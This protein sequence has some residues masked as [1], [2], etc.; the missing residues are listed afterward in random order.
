[1][2]RIALSLGDFEGRW[3]LSRV[4][5]DAKSGGQGRFEGVAEFSPTPDGLRY[6]ETG[7][8]RLEGQPGFT[9]S[10]VYHWRNAG[11]RI[12]V[13][14]DDD[15]PFHDFDLADEAEARHWCD[16]DHYAVRYD[17]HDWPSWS[18]RWAVKGPRK[19]YVMTSRYVSATA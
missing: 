4:I 1:M 10:R 13:T 14:F 9:A 16:P 7:T 6:E 11:A 3:H 19:D 2:G 15:R 8:L 5:E 18:A 17:F 12:A